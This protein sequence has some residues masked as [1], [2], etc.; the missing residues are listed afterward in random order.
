MPATHTC[1][2]P[3]LLLF[4]VFDTLISVGREMSETR[5]TTKHH[6]RWH[7]VV[8]QPALLDG[9]LP[10]PGISPQL[11]CSESAASGSRNAAITSMS[12]EKLLAPSVT[13]TNRRK[14]RKARKTREGPK[15]GLETTVAF[16]LNQEFRVEAN[17]TSVLIKTWCP[18]AGRFRPQES[19]Q[20]K[21][22]A[23]GRPGRVHCHQ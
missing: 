17:R 3:L 15:T 5:T 20:W 2:P 6:V 22:R 19:F 21:S 4:P 13:M 23:S 18:F 1:L 12:A 9:A 8:T 10:V 14:K 16:W 7:P 11:F